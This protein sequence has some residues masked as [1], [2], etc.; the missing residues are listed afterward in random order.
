MQQT[1]KSKHN[2]KYIEVGIKINL[3]FLISFGRLVNV[4]AR[5]KADKTIQNQVRPLFIAK[6]QIKH[7]IRAIAY[8]M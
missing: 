8:D 6:S 7:G 3:C 5:S 2:A 4:N 1:P